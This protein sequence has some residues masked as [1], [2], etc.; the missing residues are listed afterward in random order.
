[1]FKIEIKENNVLTNYAEFKTVPECEAWELENKDYFPQGYTSNIVNIAQLKQ[2]QSDE[3]KG[4]AN[5]ETGRKVLAKIYAINMEKIRLGLIDQAGLQAILTNP[6][7]ATIERLLLNGSI[8]SALNLIN[9]M[10][11]TFFSA[12]QKTSIVLFI[13]ANL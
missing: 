1:M 5:Q 11:D 4:Y 12:D 9:N 7:L 6:T 2:F 10:P 13:Q 8:G 3:K